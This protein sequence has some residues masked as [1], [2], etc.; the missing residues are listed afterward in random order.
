MSLTLDENNATYQ[1]RGYQPGRI[2][3]NDRL[4][5]TSV[6]IAPEKLIDFWRP[7]NITD[8]EAHDFSIILSLRPAI[9]LIGTGAT[10]RFPHAATYGELINQGIGVEVMDTNAACRTYNALSA[11]GRDVTAALIIS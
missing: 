11:E 6:I 1:I 7:Q 9:L 10:L 8:L 2:Q 3:I 5:H 4:F